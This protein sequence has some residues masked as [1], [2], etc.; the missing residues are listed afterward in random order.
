MKC[1][2]ILWSSLGPSFYVLS[3]SIFP[4]FINNILG[5]ISVYSLSH[6]IGFKQ[7]TILLLLLQ[8][9]INWIISTWI[10]CVN[11]L[12]GL[13]SSCDLEWLLAL[14]YCEGIFLP[15][16][17]VGTPPFLSLRRIVVLFLQVCS[18]KMI[19]E[20]LDGI[21]PRFIIWY[22]TAFYDKTQYCGLH[23]TLLF[24]EMKH[25]HST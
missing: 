2:I 13:V 21:K 1:N 22:S 8:P 19:Y 17:P 20:N 6:N 4:S 7:Q 16:S 18:Y 11:V 12:F 5:L 25:L 15:I 9:R 14:L 23:S 3:I 24:N 10:N